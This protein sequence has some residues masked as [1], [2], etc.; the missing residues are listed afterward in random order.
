[1]HAATQA[2]AAVRDGVQL[3]AS[4]AYEELQARLTAHLD[5]NGTVT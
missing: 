5:A 4:T 1:M 2:V 3:P